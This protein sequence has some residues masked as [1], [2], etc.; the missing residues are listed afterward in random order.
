M[1]FSRHIAVALLIALTAAAPA[2]AE[3]KPPVPFVVTVL[4]ASPETGGVEDGAEAY[5]RLL[6]ESIRYES[7][8]VLESH[9]IEVQLNEIGTVEMPVGRAFRFRPIGRGDRGVLVAIDWETRGDF[10]LRRGQPLVLGGL[11]YQGGKLVVILEAE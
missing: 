3:D 7:L 8:R 1:R 5:D 11:D 10:R 6:R 9:Q 2:L 4:H